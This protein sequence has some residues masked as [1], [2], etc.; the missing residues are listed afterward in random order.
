[1]LNLIADTCYST[2]G[3][4]CLSVLFQNFLKVFLLLTICDQKM[5]TV[6]K[7]LIQIGLAN[8]YH[9][10]G[11]EG[12]VK[13]CKTADNDNNVS[14]PDGMHRYYGIRRQPLSSTLRHTVFHP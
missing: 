12:T 10:V 6:A 1:M 14:S 7:L 8:S 5:I 9:V 4:D 2:T 13:S 3:C 11:T